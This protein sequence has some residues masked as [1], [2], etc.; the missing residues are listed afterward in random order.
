MMALI[1]VSLLASWTGDAAVALSPETNIAPTQ[2]LD[3]G[4]YPPEPRS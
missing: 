2:N 3:G 1:L 4:G